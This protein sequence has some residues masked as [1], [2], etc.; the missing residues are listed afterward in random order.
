MK[1]R[2]VLTLALAIGSIFVSMSASADLVEFTAIERAGA[3]GTWE[4][5]LFDGANTAVPPQASGNNPLVNG[6]DV[7][8]S[9]VYDGTSTLTY[10]WGNAANSLTNSIFWNGFGVEQFN[11]LTITAYDYPYDGSY[12]VVNVE[13]LTLQTTNGTLNGD[14]LTAYF[15]DNSD[16][17][18]FQ[19]ANDDV[20]GAFTLTGLTNIW[21]QY[22]STPSYDGALVSIVGGLDE[23]TGHHGGHPGCVVPEPASMTLLGLGLGGF[24]ARRLIQ[25]KRA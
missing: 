19:Y 22:G 9:L 7:Y 8:W 23:N 17:F 15:L 25:R 12:P 18:T 3:Y 2:T 4:F 21:W 10:S 11:Y 14:D 20:F 6:A 5:G 16:S 13:D 24:A 1:T